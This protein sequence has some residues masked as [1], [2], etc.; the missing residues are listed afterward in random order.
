VVARLRLILLGGFL[1]ALCSPSAGVRAQTEDDLFSQVFGNRAQAPAPVELE[2]DLTVQGVAVGPVRATIEG[3]QLVDVDRPGLLL[4]FESFIAED[5]LVPLRLEDERL[6]PEEL[7]AI[8]IDIAYDPAALALQVEVPPEYRIE[9]Q[10]PIAPVRPPAAGRTR[11]DAARFSGGL[12][13]QPSLVH[14]S[15]SNDFESALLADGFLNLGGWALASEASWSER[16][17]VLRRGPMRLHRDLTDQRLRLTVGELRSPA[18]GL[19]PALPIRGISIGRVF[20]I[21]PYNPPFPGLVAPLLLEAPTEVEVTVDG[22]LVERVRLPAGPTLLSDFPFRAGLND[23]RIDLFQDGVLQNQLTYQGWFDRIRLG[24]GQQEY[25]FSVGQPWLLGTRRPESEQ[26]EPWISSAFRRGING[27][28]TTGI[29]VLADTASGDAVFD[30]SND[31]GFERWSLSS[32]LAI[33]RDDRPGTAGTLSLQQ[34]PMRGRIWSLRWALGWRDSRFRP[35]GIETPP[36]RELRSEFSASRPL[37]DDLRWSASLRLT[38][39]V[40]G[41]EG[42]LSSVIS[43]RPSPAWSVQLRAAAL[44]SRDDQDVGLTLSLDWRPNR[45]K[46]AFSTEL[47]KR[48][49]WLAGWRYNDQ[50]ARSGRNANLVV[51]Q[52]D[53]EQA[54]SGS[55]GFRNHRIRA[56]IDHRWSIG[57]EGRTR[58]AAQSALVFADGRFGISDRVGESFV[59]FAA[60]PG[61]GRVEINPD[62]DDW[63]SRSGVLGPAVIGDLT[64]YLQRGFTL[65]LPDVPIRSDPGDLQPVA[66][67][68]FLQGVVIPVGPVPGV[69]LQWTLVNAAGEPVAL[70]AGELVPEDGR[71]PSLFFSNREGRVELGSIPPGTYRIRIATL[72]LELPVTVAETPEIQDLGELSP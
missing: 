29:G 1:A 23:V 16:S 31:L 18:F 59:L 44:K 38:D 46:H 62:G 49:D 15:R 25:H 27:R 41:R 32:D 72:G 10:V 45:G 12:N 63:R 52:V 64:P 34:E 8:G 7:A 13:L 39:Q 35:F 33:S 22:R 68:G 24:T 21:D 6:A 70:A 42:R 55:M 14:E 5:R 69:T 26:S 2:L 50:S 37:G 28:W 48:G 66:V 47:D 20:S 17:G 61:T 58:L 57:D 30:W 51:Q 53:D 3:T 43:W 40:D 65:G 67:G 4:L 56:G 19:Q 9:W 60:R 11:Y 54:L 71:E 36:G